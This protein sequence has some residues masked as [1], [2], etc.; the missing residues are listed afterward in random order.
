ME[1]KEDIVYSLEGFASLAI[2]LGQAEK[3]A[4][5]FAWAD[6][7]R[8]SVHDTRPPVEQ[9][10]VDRDAAIILEHLGEEAY[11]AAYAQGRMLATEQAVALALELEVDQIRY[12]GNT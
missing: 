5:L 12:N 9:K 6:A 7:T 1:H 11:A 10:D 8:A 2:S 4:R 3:A